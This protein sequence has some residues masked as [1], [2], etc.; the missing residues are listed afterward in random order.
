MSCIKLVNLI[1]PYDD[2]AEAI[3]TLKSLIS[4]GLVNF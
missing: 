4:K 3:P 2:I 1:L